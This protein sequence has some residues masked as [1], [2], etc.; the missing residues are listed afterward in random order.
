M[1]WEEGEPSL[2]LVYS[3][4]LVK[5]LGAS[6]SSGEAITQRHKNIAASLQAKDF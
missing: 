5:L 4:D 3:E 6:R 1:T 2:G